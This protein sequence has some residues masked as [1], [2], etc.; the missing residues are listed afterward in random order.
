MTWDF[1]KQSYVYVPAS[2][3][4]AVGN[5]IPENNTAAGGGSGG[6]V[7]YWYPATSGGLEAGDEMMSHLQGLGIQ[8]SGAPIANGYIIACTNTL[9][10]TG[11]TITTL[12]G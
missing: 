10:G 12:G 5:Y 7:N 6:H 2:A 3:R 4:D 8:V 9:S 11:C 1:S